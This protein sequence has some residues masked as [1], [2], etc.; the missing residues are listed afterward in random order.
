MRARHAPASPNP[1]S[2]TSLL[3]ILLLLGSVTVDAACTAESLDI[4]MCLDVSTSIA[5]DA[6]RKSQAQTFARSLTSQ[7]SLGEVVAGGSDDAGSVKTRIAVLHFADHVKETSPTFDHVESDINDKIYGS[8]ST[9]TSPWATNTPLCVQNAVQLFTSTDGR[10]VADA[11][12]VIVILTD[13]EPV[14][15]DLSKS[16]KNAKDNGIAVVVVALEFGPDRSDTVNLRSL[17]SNP[18]PEPGMNDCS[19][20]DYGLTGL[21]CSLQCDDRFVLVRTFSELN[22]PATRNRVVDATCIQPGCQY[23]WTPFGDCL[24]ASDGAGYARERTSVPWLEPGG[25]SPSC[26]TAPDSEPCKLTDS[27]ANCACDT[28][29]NVP[30][31]ACHLSDPSSNMILQERRCVPVTIPIG[32]S[33][34]SCRTEKKVGSLLANTYLLQFYFLSPIKLTPCLFT[35]SPLIFFPFSFTISVSDSPFPARSLAKP[36]NGAARS[37]AAL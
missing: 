6:A 17:A 32:S 27:D 36:S 35:V 28:V 37:R 24:S 15:Q 31:D 2:G 21:Q 3:V 25:N 29:T 7:Y 18:C 4:V 34:G 14:T 9:I 22:T 13:G 23:Q 5:D 33:S 8:G 16:V 11:A 30:W 26:P 10:D 12:R 20:G 19:T 1:P